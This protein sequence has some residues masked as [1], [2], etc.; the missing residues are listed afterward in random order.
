ML[1]ITVQS[2]PRAALCASD[3]VRR[4]VSCR[5]Y[6]CKPV[7]GW[8]T[9]VTVRPLLLI[10]LGG[11]NQLFGLDETVLIRADAAIDAPGCAASPF[12]SPVQV[13]GAF[14]TND[15]DPGSGDDPRE[16][17]LARLNG[18]NKYDIWIAT[19]ADASSPFDNG[20]FFAHNSAEHDGDAAVSADG[21]VVMFLSHRT[22][23]IGVYESTR[24]AIGAT[25]TPPRAVTPGGDRGI[26]LS[27]DG[28]TLYYMN[29]DFGLRAIR[30][31]TRDQPFGPP[32]D[33]LATGIEWPSVS[34][35][36]LEVYFAKPLGQGMYRRTR[37]STSVAFD[38]AS[39]TLIS[40]GGADPDVS[41]DSTRLYFVSGGGVSVMTR[42]CN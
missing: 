8:A 17:W 32:G 16:L 12:A 36:E 41:S 29:V 2:A 30:R 9:M 4:I 38:D 13:E 23:A 1:D 27:V 33:V 24:T 26:D 10:A 21:L 28:L 39:E 5:A 40:P 19:R 35:D 20:S 15:V 22:S 3:I 11:C 25:F 6:A 42:T 14:V 7:C 34:P 18:S 31:P 37:G